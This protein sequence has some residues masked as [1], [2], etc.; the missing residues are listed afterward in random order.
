MLHLN[1]IKKNTAAKRKIK[2]HTLKIKKKR[3]NV[4]NKTMKEA[5]NTRGRFGFRAKK[6]ATFLQ[7][8]LIHKGFNCFTVRKQYMVAFCTKRLLA[9]KTN[10]HIFPWPLG[11]LWFAF[12]CCLKTLFCHAVDFPSVGKSWPDCSN[13]IP[14]RKCTYISLQPVKFLV[15]NL[16]V[17]FDLEPSIYFR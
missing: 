12:A 4:Y 9:D 13:C 10:R 11:N 14:A 7:Y 16:S 1:S 3:L 5:S 17:E 8:Y 15:R 6:F 2:F